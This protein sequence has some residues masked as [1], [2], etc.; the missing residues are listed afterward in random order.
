LVKKVGC[1]AG[2]IPVHGSETHFGFDF[3]DSLVPLAPGLTAVERCILE[4]AVA[5]VS[6]IWI[7][8]N[9][10]IEPL[11]KSRIGESI[12]IGGTNLSKFIDL[13]DKEHTKVNACTLFGKSVPIFYVPVRY[14]D[15]GEFDGLAWDIIQGALT[16]YWVLRKLS[17][18]ITAEKFYVSFPMGIY[19]PRPLC[20]ELRQKLHEAPGNLFLT[21]GGK[22]VRDNL[23]LG[24]AF[25]Q[26]D[27]EILFTNF[28][29]LVR[30]TRT[31]ADP[32]EKRI[33]W[34]DE[35]YK[36]QFSMKNMLSGIIDMKQT[37]KIEIGW[38]HE[39][40]TW[41]KYLA[42]MGSPQAKEIREFNAKFPMAEYIT[43]Q[44]RSIERL[45]KCWDLERDRA[46]ER[47][48]KQRKTLKL[49]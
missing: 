49:T 36:K 5:G 31:S 4:M 9:A 23:L 6:S 18:W 12:S 43:H 47:F 39:I 26:W 34:K 15:F 2:I 19:D 3:H 33:L 14:K 46:E 40:D 37:K 45:R 22:S 42:Y 10:D 7:V 29:K 1:V 48:E 41:E 25:D 28:K 8:C 17:R 24:F 35:K 32:I 44:P 16:S 21:I 11:I 30:N 20:S 13:E 27:L 38:H